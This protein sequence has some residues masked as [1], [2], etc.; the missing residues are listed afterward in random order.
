MAVAVGVE[1]AESAAQEVVGVL[2]FLAVHVVVVVAL[3]VHH[4]HGRIEAPRPGVVVAP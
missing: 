2:E 3:R 4:A 1:Q